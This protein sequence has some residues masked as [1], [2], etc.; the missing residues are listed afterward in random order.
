MSARGAD[1]QALAWLSRGYSVAWVA[2]RLGVPEGRVRAAAEREARR[3]ERGGRP[4]RGEG[5]DGRV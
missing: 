4:R 1:A 2:A 3:I 5:A